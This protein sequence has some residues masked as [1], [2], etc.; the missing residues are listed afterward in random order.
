MFH[1]HGLQPG[2]VFGGDFR[3][4]RALAMGGM[5]AVYVVEQLSTGRKRALKLLLPSLLQNEKSRERFEQE[6]RVA[7][8][9]QSDHVVEVVAAGVDAASGAPW[10]AME[11]LEGETLADRLARTGPMRPAEV[12]EVLR[13][14]CHA[15]GAAHATGLVHRDIKPENIYLAAPRREGIPFT[16]KILDFGIAKLTEDVRGQGGATGAIG[17]PL[18]MAPEQASAAGVG[19]PADVWALGLVVF[20]CLTARHYWRSAS[21]PDATLQ[22][23]LKEV[24]FDP[25]AP[26]S[27]RASELGAAGLLPPG[28]DDWFGRTVVREPA[29]RFAD[30]TAALAA[31]HPVLNPLS[32]TLTL[33]SAGAGAAAATLPSATPSV[34]AAFSATAPASTLHTGAV[35]RPAQG[36]KALRWVLAGLG[37][38]LV[39]GVAV[40]AVAAV[41]F[42]YFYTMEG[43]A[44]PAAIAPSGNAGPT[45]AAPDEAPGVAATAA[46]EQGS[47][48]GAKKVTAQS[49]T[50]P[51]APGAASATATA[52]AT[53]APSATPAPSSTAIAMKDVSD[54]PTRDYKLS[55]YKD[56]IN[57]CWKGNEGAKPDAGS[58][59]ATITVK[60]N[61]IG[62]ASS[63][64]VSPRPYPCFAGCAVV[65]SSEHPWGKGPPE[66]KSFAF[67][68]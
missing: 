24:M 16:L 51:A 19:P 41:A 50:A 27:A 35:A 60:L 2:D 38:L 62:Q 20:H 47:T 28:F 66:T 17:S 15:L 39:G 61:E 34:P 56:K 43:D 59:S 3:I 65:R 58:Y 30:A 25:L 55:W 32:P 36:G 54:Y 11:L 33:P 53:A 45:A 63:V 8:R 22:G 52:T 6:A 4:E 46:A 49:P 29:H 31:L 42:G 26:A 67:S 44:K 37:L 1:P 57:Q 21:A 23:L 10:L 13:Q 48:T 12:L 64:S 18:W 68:F 5:G 9:I 40:V 7:S 14:L